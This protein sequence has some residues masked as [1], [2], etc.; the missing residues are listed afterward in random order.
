MERKRISDELAGYVNSSK[1]WQDK[2]FNKTT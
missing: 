2:R 1:I